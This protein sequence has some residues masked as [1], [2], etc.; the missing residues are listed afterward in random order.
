MADH[1]EEEVTTELYYEIKHLEMNGTF[2]NCNI[3]INAGSP[4]QPPPPPPGDGEG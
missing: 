2:T 3:F 4:S 1:E